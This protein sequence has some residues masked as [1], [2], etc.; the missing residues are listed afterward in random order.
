MIE[1]TGNSLDMVV[2]IIQI[3]LTPIFLL[4]AVANLLSVFT[5]RLARVA[6]QV[7]VLA[8]QFGR[9]EKGADTIL[10]IRLAT[11]KRRSLLLDG[12]VVL[13]AV[14]GACTCCTVLTLFLGLLR[15]AAT[16]TILLGF[17]GLGILCTVGAL[18]AF[19][20][21]V[22]LASRGIR[23]TMDAKVRRVEF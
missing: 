20:S 8:D 14:S 19:L 13:A 11:L 12:A 2:H 22:M 16:Q 18:A 10:L 5:T 3:S 23:E 9:S 17:F 1:S 21:E 7:N 4:T 6:D 15:S